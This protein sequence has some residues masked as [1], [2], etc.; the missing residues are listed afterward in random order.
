MNNPNFGKFAGRNLAELEMYLVRYRH[1][2]E[3]HSHRGKSIHDK[4]GRVRKPRVHISQPRTW[5]RTW[6]ES[7]DAFTTKTLFE[8]LQRGDNQ[9]YMSTSEVRDSPCDDGLLWSHE[10]DRCAQ[11]GRSFVVSNANKRQVKKR[12]RRLSDS[13]ANQIDAAQVELCDLLGEGAFGCVYS[14][15]IL[16]EEIAVKFV[17]DVAATREYV[18]RESMICSRLQHPNVLRTF[19]LRQ[20]GS[21]WMIVMELISG[22]PLSEGKYSIREV[23]KIVSKLAETVVFLD[24]NCIVHRDIKPS[25]IILRHCDGNPV[26]IDFGVAI[27]T[28]IQNT[29]RYS[30]AGTPMFMPPE[31]VEGVVTTA[32]D[33]YSLGVTFATMM[34][35]KLGT[36]NAPLYKSHQ[37]LFEAK[38]NGD[39]SN[40]ICEYLAGMDNSTLILINNLIDVDPQKRIDA[41]RGM[42]NPGGMMSPIKEL[43]RKIVTSTIFRTTRR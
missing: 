9:I 20:V 13:L 4:L 32:F 5:G 1:D 17:L 43:L 36:V 26:L 40:W 6:H 22:T 11:L 23:T 28:R 12:N 39:F 30:I 3:E 27:D 8:Q 31:S 37:D 21:Y 7:H 33:A 35:P 34:V 38:K 42:R 29:N 15:R 25:N 16:G 2:L 18:L 14:A 41:L 10:P 24:E 19:D